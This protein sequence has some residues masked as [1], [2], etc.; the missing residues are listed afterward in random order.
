MA[1]QGEMAFQGHQH[2]NLMS[3]EPMQ[4]SATAK[5]PPISGQQ[6]LYR[7]EVCLKIMYYTDG[8]RGTNWT[9]Y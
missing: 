6:Q 4:R 8:Q 2:V 5:C 3:H 1:A 7:G 9:L